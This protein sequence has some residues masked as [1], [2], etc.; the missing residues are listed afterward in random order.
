[1]AAKR[2]EIRAAA[3]ERFGRDGYEDTKWADIDEAGFYRSRLLR[4]IGF[5]PDGPAPVLAA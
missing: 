1:M 2:A 3:T 5:D 4:V